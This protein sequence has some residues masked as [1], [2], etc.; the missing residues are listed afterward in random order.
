M[1]YRYVGPAE[2]YS[3]YFEVDEVYDS[4]YT[5]YGGEDSQEGK[6]FLLVGQYPNDWEEVPNIPNNNSIKV[7]RKQ[8]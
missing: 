4:T 1:K 2:D 3:S 5:M 8:I 7:L 6:V